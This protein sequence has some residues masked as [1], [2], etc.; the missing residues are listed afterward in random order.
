M[1]LPTL[2]LEII[3]D[4]P[5]ED[6]SEDGPSKD[7][8]EDGPSGGGPSGGGPSLKDPSRRRP[9]NG[10]TYRDAILYLDTILKDRIAKATLPQNNNMRIQIGNKWRELA[11]GEGTSLNPF[12]WTFFLRYSRPEIVQEVAVH[13]DRTFKENRLLFKCKGDEDLKD[14]NI[15]RDG[16]GT[17]TILAD[18]KLKREWKW[19]PSHG[20]P[21]RSMTFSWELTSNGLRQHATYEYVILREV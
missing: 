5:S 12:R 14:I 16:W 1:N 17:F 10:W 9:E 15:T 8:S 4:G 11:P 13:L 19:N 21:S 6:S 7:S 20:Q 18:I 2:L 3:E